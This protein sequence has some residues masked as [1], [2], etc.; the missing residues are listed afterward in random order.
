MNIRQLEKVSDKIKERD[1][2][3]LEMYDRILRDGPLSDYI[4]N[5]INWLI[6]EN[7]QRRKETKDIYLKLGNIE[8]IL[9]ERGFYKGI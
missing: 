6:N 5:I 7:E 4:K 2:K 9:K 8:K 3:I 1:E